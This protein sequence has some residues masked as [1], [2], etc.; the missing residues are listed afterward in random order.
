[1]KN[2]NLYYNEIND[3]I[4]VDIIAL[5]YQHKDN[6]H[7]VA[8]NINKD[9]LLQYNIGGKATLTINKVC[10]PITYGTIFYI[11]PNTVWSLQSDESDPCEYFFVN[12]RGSKCKKILTQCGLTKETPV[13][14]LYNYDIV[15]AFNEMIDTFK[16]TERSKMAKSIS[17]LYKIFATLIENNASEKV[18]PLNENDY[19]KNAILYIQ[20]NYSL[21]ITIEDVAEA[22]SVNRNYFS[23]I[24]K[25]AMKTTPINYLINYRLSQAAPLL[26]T[27]M[28]PISEISKLC[29][30]PTP[31]AFTTRFKEY[32][33]FS[34]REYRKKMS[35]T[36][37]ETPD[38]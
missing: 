24:F 16:T 28:L 12:F 2:R 32:S 18:I 26:S 14:N 5:G 8:Q 33:G 27:T 25:A 6:A 37:K 15:W 23:R 38:D 22:L 19:V 35:L 10:Y 13:L 20:R 9:N 11:S 30:F 31:I 17:C 36:K 1:M 21:G 7:R 34:P 29:G 3:N 4:D